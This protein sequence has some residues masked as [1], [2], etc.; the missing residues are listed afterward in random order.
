MSP[1]HSSTD[2]ELDTG[3]VAKGDGPAAAFVLALPRLIPED[4]RF[5][6]EAVLYLSATWQR[7]VGASHPLKSVFK[8]NKQRQCSH[9][10]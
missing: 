2:L 3:A 4:D 9:V 10:P 6:V 8:I 7:F 1:S 5:V